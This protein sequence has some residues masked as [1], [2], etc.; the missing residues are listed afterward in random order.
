[1]TELTGGPGLS[2]RW[3]GTN[4]FGEMR[5]LKHSGTTLSFGVTF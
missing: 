3:R 4:L 2:T 1:M 5:N